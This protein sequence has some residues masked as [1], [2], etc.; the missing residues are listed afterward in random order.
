L[1]VKVAF[2]SVESPVTVPTTA[3]TA[4]P[5]TAPARAK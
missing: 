3:H 1:F 5:L 2:S 4:V